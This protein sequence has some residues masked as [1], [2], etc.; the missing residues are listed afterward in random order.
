MRLTKDVVA[1]LALPTGKAEAFFWDDDVPGL[2]LRLREGGSRTWVFQFRVGHRQRRLT[3]AAA[4][5]ISVADA[6]AIAAKLHARTRLGED[7]AEAKQKAIAAQG[8]TVEAVLSVYLA[9]QRQRLRPRSYVEVARHLLVHAR[10][11]HRLTVDGVDRRAIAKVLA[12]V[13][14]TSGPVAANLVRTSLSAFFA[15]AAR[16]GM[17]DDNRCSTRTN[18]MLA[19]RENAFC[20]M[21]SCARSGR[22]P[23]VTTN[24]LR[25]CDCCF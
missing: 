19:G 15:W 1:K 21:A 12:R 22:R 9:R 25:S 20:P 5:A 4:S 3:V 23:A 16:E 14:E 24:I 10:A 7:P 13:G 11:L 18:S 2:G 17:R 6:R 8:E